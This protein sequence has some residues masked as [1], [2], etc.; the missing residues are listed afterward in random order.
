L[1]LYPAQR[2]WRRRL[3]GIFILVDRDGPFA[4]SR[5]ALSYSP[6][7]VLLHH[8][9]TDLVLEVGISIDGKWLICV[10]IEL[11]DLLFGS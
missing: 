2:E 9:R 7:L 8:G 11:E 10:D 5:N 6:R 1:K 3:F 4:Q